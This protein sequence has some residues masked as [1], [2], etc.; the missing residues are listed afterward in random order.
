MGVACFFVLSGF[1]YAL[2]Y[3]GKVLSS[4]FRYGDF[5]KG[6]LVKFYPLHWITLLLAIPVSLYAALGWKNILVFGANFLLI[7]SWI[8]ISTVYYSYNGVSWFLS[9][10]V[11]LVAVFPFVFRW[12]DSRNKRW[13]YLLFAGIAYCCI[14]IVTPGPH[15]NTVL[16]VNPI[17][18]LCDFTVGILAGMWYQR[19]VENK[20]VLAFVQHNKVLLTF[21]PIVCFAILL[22]LSVFLSE[23][24]T[25]MAWIF[26]PAI[27]IMLLSVSVN[28]GGMLANPFLH[29][30]GTISFPFYMIHQLVIRYVSMLCNQFDLNLPLTSTIP[31]TLILS[32]AL[33]MFLNKFVLSLPKK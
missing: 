23:R 32:I 10:M 26:W 5:I 22:L 31:I 11:F 16:Y 1:C 14:C 17:V 25:L 19:F 13:I 7:Q 9:D 8:P 30:L 27:V 6:R 15:R 2:G 3:G 12:L 24:Y 21:I 4:D 28:P 33:S 18:R 29:R 20:A